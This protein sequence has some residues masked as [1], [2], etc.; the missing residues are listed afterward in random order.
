[1]TKILININV[2]NEHNYV[3]TLLSAL[4][5]N[6]NEYEPITMVLSC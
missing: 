5:S 2:K 6:F 4:N 3:L 1:M